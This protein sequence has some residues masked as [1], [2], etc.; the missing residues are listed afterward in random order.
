MYIEDLQKTPEGRKYLADCERM[1]KTEP[2][3][4]ALKQKGLT[5][6]SVKE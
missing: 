5:Y 1:A 4:E 2:D 6:R 3:T